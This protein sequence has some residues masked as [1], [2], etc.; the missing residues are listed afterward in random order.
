VLKT[1]FSVE[2]PQ[3]RLFSFPAFIAPI[4]LTFASLADLPLPASRY[5]CRHEDL[6]ASLPL[7][8]P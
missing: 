4:L 1:H 2:L 7:V 5:L 3:V 8:L 6:G